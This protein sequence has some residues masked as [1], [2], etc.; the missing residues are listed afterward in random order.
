MRSEFEKNRYWIGLYRTD[1]DF[2]ENLG[3]FGRYVANGSRRF[4]AANLETFNEKWEVYAN[5]WQ[6]RQTEVDEL[7]STIEKQ[8]KL[9]LKAI[10]N[11][12]AGSCLELQLAQKLHAESSPDSLESERDMN[13]LLTNE[14]LLLESRVDV[15]QKRVDAALQEINGA[16]RWVDEDAIDDPEFIK[17]GVL[18]AFARLEQALKGGSNGL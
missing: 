1:V 5:A 17:G 8:K 15:L 9:S 7:K 14:N 12:K 16:T 10:E 4:D 18:R 13:S 2:D 11:A 3:E 6:H